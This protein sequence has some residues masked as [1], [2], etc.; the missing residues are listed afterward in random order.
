MPYLPVQKRRRHPFS[1]YKK[2]GAMKQFC[3]LLALSLLLPVRLSAQPCTEKKY[4]WWVETDLLY[5]KDVNY[6][7]D[8]LELRLDLYK[9][10]GD[11]NTKRPLI[12]VVHGGYFYV[13]CKEGIRWFAEEMVARGY[14]VAAVDYR[15][16]WHKHSF[17]GTHICTA[18]LLFANKIEEFRSLYVADSAEHYRALYRGMQDVRG[19]IRW[20][21]ARAD[22]DSVDHTK[23]FVGGES[24]GAAISLAVA[25]LDRPE[26]KP[27]SCGA[28]GIAPQPYHPQANYFEINKCIGVMRNPTYSQRLRPDLGPVEGRLNLNGH[29]TRVLGVF[30][31]Y[32][33]VPYEALT[34]NWISG[35]NLPATYLYH[36]TCDGLVPFTYGQISDVMSRNCNTGCDPWH[37][38]VMYSWGNG[39]IANYIE[40][41]PNPPRLMKEFLHCQP[42]NSNLG[43]AECLRFLD[44]GMYHNILEKPKRAQNIANFFAPLACPTVTTR[45]IG[46]SGQ[47]Q[48]QP[49]PF[50]QE[51]TVWIDTPISGDAQWWLTDLSGRVVW[52]AQRALPIGRH[53]LLEHNTLP[54]GVYVLH[55]RSSEGAGAWKVIRQ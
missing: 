52:S 20:L 16:G 23:V 35:P 34:Y 15:K 38:R 30:S 19:A 29:D 5:G 43:W 21:K 39:A 13:G 55:L 49:N 18:T 32:G 48:V 45:E 36:R 50:A 37:L 14:V 7:G 17:V 11:N 4:N 12:V 8:S 51:L 6:L 44:N 1:S 47:V 41:M 26:E 28:I 31:F 3:T 27:P 2:E 22:Q 25:F 54:T 42:F 24:A 46:L 40:A 53:V 9:P 33:A 10:I